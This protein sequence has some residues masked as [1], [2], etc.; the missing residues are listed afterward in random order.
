MAMNLTD[1]G[2]STS[3]DDHIEIEFTLHPEARGVEDEWSGLT[4]PAAR[5]KLQNRLNQR[6]YSQFMICN[7]IERPGTNLIVCRKP[8]G[9]QGEMRKECSRP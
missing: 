4:D 9:C 2:T 8:P 6:A 3:R 7:C 5:R 1:L